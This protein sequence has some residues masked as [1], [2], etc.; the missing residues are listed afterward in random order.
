MAN[1]KFE[2]TLDM[3][4]SGKIAVYADSEEEAHAIIKDL[5]ENHL[6]KID[7]GDIQELNIVDCA[8][9]V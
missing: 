3:Q 8:G 5:I 2:F 6:S 9:V 4:C 1:T 7:L